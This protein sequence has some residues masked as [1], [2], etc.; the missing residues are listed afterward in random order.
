[1]WIRFIRAGIVSIVATVVLAVITLAIIETSA[2]GDSADLSYRTLDYDVTAT[3]NGDLK[4]TQHI[5]VKMRERTDSDDN[6]K[7]WKQLFQQYTLN[8]GTLTDISDISV[9]NVTDGIDYAQQSEP[10]LPS[11]VFSDKEWNSDYANHWYVADVSDGSDHPK[12]Y[13]PG[14]DGL[15]PSASATEDDTTVEIGWNIPVTTEADSMKF[16]VS[17]TMHD[18]ATKWKDV[19]SF[20]WEPFGKKNQVPIG[21]VTGTVHFPNGITGKTSWAWLHTERTSETKRNSDGSYTFTAYNIHNGDYLDVVAA[22]DAAKAKG[23]ARKGTGNHLKDLKQDEYK[24]QQ[25]WLDKQRF[26]ARARLVSWIVSIVLGIALCA[27]G[28]WAVIS[29]NR[30]AQYRGSVEYWRDQPG[31]SPA[32]AAR[33]IRVV[34]PSTR[35]SD[36][37]RQLT[38]TMLSLAV[39]KAIAVYP[40]PSDMY[41][42]IDMSQATPVGLSQMIAADQGKQYAAGITST[43]VILPLAIDEAPNA[44]QLGL[45]ESEDALL[46]LL[47]VISQRVGS[48]VF[49]LNQMKATCQNWQDGY[50]EL[51][52]FTGACS[53]EYQ[54]LGATR[55]VGWQW[56]LPGVLAAVLGFG[57]LLANSFIGYPVAGLI[58]LPIFLVGLF[59][60]MAGAMTVLT[61]QGQDIAGRTLGLKRYMEDFSNF[62]DRGT[63]DL[64]L[65]DWYMVYAAAFGISDRVMREL[66]KAYPQVNDPAWLDANASNSLFYWNY[67]PYGWHQ[68]DHQRGSTIRRFRW[69]FLQLRLGWRLRF[70]WLVRRFGWRLVRW[71][72]N[73]AFCLRWNRTQTVSLLLKGITMALFRNLGPFSTTAIGHG[74]MPLTI[75]NNRGHEVGIETLHASLDAGC[76]HID[77]A[78]AYY[79]SGGE[80]QTG[81]KLVREALETWKGS[82]DEVLVATKVGHF[83][84]FTDGRPTWDVDGRPENLIRR[85]KESALA[86]GV[87]TIDLL[88]FHRPDPK[89]PYNESVEAIKQLV[90][91]GVAQ[92]AGI[93]NA[94]IEQIDIARGILGDKLVAVQNQY[95]PIHLETQDTLDYCAKVGLAFVCWSPL[96]GYRHPYDETKFDPFRE[97]AAAHGVS[98]QQV[99]LAWE[100]AKGDHMFVIPGAHRPETILDS[101]KA[102]QLELTP[103]ELAKLG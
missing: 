84:N 11:D 90:D 92:E 6:T 80:E 17:F 2:F 1:M 38:A 7:P 39:K 8:S 32:S 51:G 65:W 23:I 34:D 74:E 87:D 20:Q 94:S 12:A 67:R 24:Q 18:V 97:V 79:C 100:L 35:Q 42:G 103:E 101:L 46:N 71:A 43:I 41:R 47:I 78:W 26:A 93:S 31:I 53:M 27:W 49:D 75:E 4:V 59:C 82:K 13:T 95:S 89:V 85:G 83:R 69:R 72:V 77:T 81:E 99:V 10:K 37:D 62:T 98:Y 102:D 64:A 40:G 70:R 19:A 91:E 86:L 73:P 88:Y 16:D 54:R 50:I 66:A 52:K 28:I 76:R 57:S 63:A 21:T 3:A 96:G 15:K 29:S 33:L 61:D 48:P 25:R 58:E 68:L 44:Q 55:S 60:S 14:T 9:R 36:E 56:I 45:S 30:R 22:F 5:D